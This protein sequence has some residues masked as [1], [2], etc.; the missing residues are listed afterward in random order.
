MVPAPIK[1]TVTA[2]LLDRLDVR[3]GTI[4]KVEDVAKSNSLGKLTVGFGDHK[5]C[6]LAGL[7]GDREHPQ[8]IEGVQTPFVVSLAPRAMMGEV[9]EGM[10][11]VVGYEG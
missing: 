10:L 8:A 7:K 3:V 6:I 11:F 9:S 2:D 1:T 4:E 5:R